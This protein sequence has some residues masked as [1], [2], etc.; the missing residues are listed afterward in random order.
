MFISVY[1]LCFCVQNNIQLPRKP[2]SCAPVFRNLVGISR[3]GN[4]TSH[5][6]FACWNKNQ[7]FYRQ[8]INFSK[9]F[10]LKNNLSGI[11]SVCQTVWIQSSLFK[12]F[13]KTLADKADS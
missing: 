2:I 9:N 6:P 8:L 10:F 1:I 5:Y 12:L 13:A 11:T 7:E 4:Y 3:F